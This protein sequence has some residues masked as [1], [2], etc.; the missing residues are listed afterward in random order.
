[1]LKLNCFVMFLLIIYCELFFP[2]WD[3]EQLKS[4]IWWPSLAHYTVLLF[5]TIV[6][7]SPPPTLYSLTTSERHKMWCTKEV[8]NFWIWFL[9]K[10]PKTNLICLFCRCGRFGKGVQFTSD[11]FLTKYV[12]LQCILPIGGRILFS[13]SYPTI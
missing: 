3:F 6:P 5:L 8:K 9:I 11:T 4:T 7:P 13:N 10:T 1:M 2:T 12:K